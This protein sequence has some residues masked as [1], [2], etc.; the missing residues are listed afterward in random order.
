MK[1]IDKLLIDARER[2]NSKEIMQYLD[3]AFS[4]SPLGGKVAET[5]P[6]KPH[7]F[8]KWLREPPKT[9]EEER[10]KGV[11]WQTIQLLASIIDGVTYEKN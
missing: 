1:K 3:Y 7:D 8:D 4:L 11:P 6:P 10:A 5:K 2:H 9:A